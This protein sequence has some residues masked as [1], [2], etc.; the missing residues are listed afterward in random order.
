MLTPAGKRNRTSW[1][2]LVGA[3]GAWAVGLY[4]AYLSDDAM[5]S[6]GHLWAF[7]LAALGNLLLL[8][9]I[10]Q[11]ITKSPFGVLYTGRNT[12][13]LSRL[14]MTA[15]TVVVLAALM[16]TAAIRAWS[17]GF[18][19]ALRIG[20]PPE[21]LQVMGISYV[22]AAAAP[23]ILA[24]KSQE[25]TSGQ[26]QAASGR[27]GEQLVSGDQLVHRPSW[28]RPRLADMVRGD[29]LNSAGTVDLGK[30]Q[31]L[32]ITGLVLVIYGG[33]LAMMF[34]WT[35]LDTPRTELPKFSTDFVTLLL[36]SHGGYLALKA[37][38]KPD[39]TPSSAPQR[40]PP[41]DRNAGT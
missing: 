35:K 34:L 18:A 22:S 27:M 5:G 8:A 38:P 36:V 13:S 37:A 11:A 16:A 7:L 6:F 10:G 15:W 26:V 14:Q 25:A 12:L 39:P 21:L 24:L 33:V 29:D 20:I 9:A 1:V 23:A 31:Q 30:V 2:F 32:M 19:G 3:L 41:P 40:P 17:G 28:A 4:C